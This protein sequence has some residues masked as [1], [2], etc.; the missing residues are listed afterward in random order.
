MAYPEIDG[1]ERPSSASIAPH[2]N[3]H[4]SIRTGLKML[5]EVNR[6]LLHR[7]DRVKGVSF[8]PTEPWLLCGLYNGQAVILNKETSAVVKSFDVSD[9]PVRCV[10]FIARKNW[11]VAGSD[12]FQL[13]VFNYNTH[14]KVTTFEAHPDYIRCLTVHPT[15][16]VVL[17]GSDD[18]SIKAWDW[19]KGWKN[20]MTYEGHTHYIM[21]LTFNPK[22][23]NSFASACLDR[24]VK[25]WSLATPQPKFTLEAHEKGVN[26]VDFYQGSDKPYLVTSSDDKSVKVWDYISK[27]CVQTLEGHTSNVSF[28]VWHPRLPILISGSEDGTVKLWNSSTYRIENTLSYALERSWC[29]KVVLKW[30]LVTT[31][32]VVV[33]K[34]GRDTPTFSMDP[35]GKLIWTRNQE[36]L[37][38]NIG[39]LNAEDL[40][41]DG[42]RISLPSKKDMGTTEIYATELFHS[43]NG[44]FI[45]ALGDG[46]YITYTALAWRNKSFGSGIGFAWSLDSNTYAVL[47]T[48]FKLKLYKNFKE[49]SGGNMKGS[50]SWGIEGIHG[51]G[52]L[53]VG[54]G[55]SFVVFWDWDSG[56]IVRRVDVDGAKNVLWSGTQ[57]LVAIVSDDGFYVLRYDQDAYSAQVEE[58]GSADFGDEGVEDAFDVVAEINDS[59]KTAKWI[60]DCFI[61]TTGTNRLAY[62]VGSESYTIGTTEQPLYVLGYIPAHNRVYLADKDVNIYSYALALSV[63]EY[64]TAV[65]RGDMDAANEILETIPKDQINRVAR[66]LEGRDLK[67]EA[68]RITTDHDHKFELA[69]SLSDL[70]TAQALLLSLPPSSAQSEE[71]QQKWKTLGDAALKAWDFPLARKAF[72]EAEDLYGLLLLGLSLGDS[73]IVKNVASKAKDSGLRNMSFSALWSVGDVQGCIDLLIE[74]GRPEE[75]ALLARTYLP[76]AV[77]GAVKAWKDSLTSKNKHKIA[78]LIADPGTNADLFEELGASLDSEGSGILV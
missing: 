77:P 43:P 22:D 11:F 65:L 17:T 37:S 49:R 69:L 55:S 73:G 78:E 52:P 36:V 8:H 56:E 1:G 54:R 21:N 63:V 44:R 35:S 4:V 18:M 34:L 57:S 2:P 31:D 48:K 25:M 15:L 72:E 14:E 47:E 10:S 33:V 51:Q 58:N 26:Y 32:G 53:L 16:P 46:E 13:R 45:T 76:S 64:Q 12:D 59:V 24:T 67:E 42:A 68:M 3:F 28:A 39:A 29:R 27:S 6:T 20:I 70:T 74:S 41:V 40:P 60:G 66:F 62:F 50:S 5:F 38:G 7:S 71:A 19:D 23:S 9:V 61:Y 30:R 75:G